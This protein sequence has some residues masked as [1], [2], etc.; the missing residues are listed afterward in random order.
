MVSKNAISLQRIC[1][2]LIFTALFCA[3]VVGLALVCASYW[4][5]PTSAMPAWI[6]AVGSVA[7][8]LASAA[9]FAADHHRQQQAAQDAEKMELA[10]LVLATHLLGQSI[11]DVIDTFVESGGS[12]GVIATAAIDFCLSQLRRAIEQNAH[13]PHW[14]MELKAAQNWH[15]TYRLA[16]SIEA[17]FL[18]V[19]SESRDST[20]TV[21]S[22]VKESSLNWQQYLM[23]TQ[24]EAAM[25][26]NALTGM[27][28]PPNLHSTGE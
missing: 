24:S 3:V 26:Y 10:N 19:R 1:L 2:T 28:I 17:S 16:T 18:I 9:L 11:S 27:E 6:Q 7:A 5:D 20:T 8:I 15:A 25:R 21:T 23:K 22:G 13:T 4:N 14:R 12:K